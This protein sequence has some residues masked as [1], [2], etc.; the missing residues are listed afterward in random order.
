[1]TELLQALSDDAR[2]EASFAASA[3]QL[4]RLAAEALEAYWAGRTQELGFDE[5]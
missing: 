5:L 3:P 4:E 1:M 2:W